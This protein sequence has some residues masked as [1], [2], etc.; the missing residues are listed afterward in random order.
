MARGE[1]YIEVESMIIRKNN[2]F[3]VDLESANSYS[4]EKVDIFPAETMLKY[5]FNVRTFG[6]DMN[7]LAF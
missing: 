4:C 7:A 2:R 6:R 5:L 1:V 3:S